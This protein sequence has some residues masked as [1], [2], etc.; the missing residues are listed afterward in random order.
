MHSETCTTSA[1]R[2]S[3]KLQERYQNRP[4]RL[5]SRRSYFPPNFSTTKESSL[6]YSSHILALE[7]D[8]CLSIILDGRG[9]GQLSLEI[10]KQTEPGRAIIVWVYTIEEVLTCVCMS[11]TPLHCTLMSPVCFQPSSFFLRSVDRLPVFPL[12]ITYG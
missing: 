6:D 4:I 7:Q 10:I 5:E 2:P 3:H 11:R 12:P 9:R 8:Q 1:K